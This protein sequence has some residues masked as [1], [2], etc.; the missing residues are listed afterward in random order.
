MRSLLRFGRNKNTLTISEYSN[1]IQAI[2]KNR[3]G[4]SNYPARSRGGRWK[5][6]LPRMFFIIIYAFHDPH[7]TGLSISMN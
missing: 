5:T 3:I 1:L 2:L 6:A 4:W 7:Q